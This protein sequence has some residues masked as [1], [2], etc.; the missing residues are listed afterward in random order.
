MISIL[1]FRF[2]WILDLILDLQSQI[3]NLGRLRKALS[4]LAYRVLAD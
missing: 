3:A 2:I 4:H 1:D